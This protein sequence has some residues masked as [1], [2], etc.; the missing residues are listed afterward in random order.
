MITPVAKVAAMNAP[1]AESSTQIAP[2]AQAV[3][4][5]DRAGWHP[6]G[7]RLRV[8]NNITLLDLP[9]Y[10]PELNPMEN[11]WEFLRAN[12]LCNLVWDS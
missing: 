2:G 7:K 3:L 6:R 1:L 12:T 4:L 8:P 5:L 11:V 10:A 9:P